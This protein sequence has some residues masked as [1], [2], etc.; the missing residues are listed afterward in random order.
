LFAAYQLVTPKV[1]ANELVPFPSNR[2]ILHFGKIK[3]FLNG[4][5]QS[6]SKLHKCS[7]WEISSGIFSDWETRIP[8]NPLEDHPLMKFLAPFTALDAA[9]QVL[10]SCPKD[11]TNSHSPD[12]RKRLERWSVQIQSRLQAFVTKIAPVLSR[13]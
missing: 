13:W 5:A 2:R 11:S 6:Y 12:N 4:S 10:G 8:I 3:F 9:T 7:N 1:D